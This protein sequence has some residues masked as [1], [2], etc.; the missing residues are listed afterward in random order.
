MIKTNCHI[1]TKEIYKTNRDFN[2]SKSGFHFC[3][4]SCAAKYNNAIYKIK[5]TEVK[6]CLNCDLDLVKKYREEAFCSHICKTEYRMKN[7]TI[8][9]SSK[10][11]DAAKY[12]NIRSAARSYSKY[13]L[14]PKC[15]KCGYDK[16]YEVCHIK[17]I[18]SFT[19][20]TKVF[21]VNN[22]KNLVHLCPN[23]H[24]EFDN[25]CEDKQLF[26]KN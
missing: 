7:I 16:H 1:C 23:C 22:I 2:N 13:F 5:Y 8:E 3:G 19:K 20:D 15:Y 9:E 17:D 12:I 25:N 10:R 6:K 21:E 26:L 4:S 14:D 18:S 24:W 11:T